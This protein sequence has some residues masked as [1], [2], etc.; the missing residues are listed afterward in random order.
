[1]KK[2][3]KFISLAVVFTGFLALSAC[4][5]MAGF[6]EDVQSSGKA[7]TKAADKHK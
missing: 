4:S 2:I 1:M 7:I 3:L 6:G 5:T